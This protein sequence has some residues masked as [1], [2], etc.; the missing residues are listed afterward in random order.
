MS[1][2]I[3]L[4]KQ[5]AYISSYISHKRWIVDESEFLTYGIQTTTAIS[6]SSDIEISNPITAE[7][8][9]KLLYRSLDQLYYRQPNTSEVLDEY[10]YVDLASYTYEKYN[11]TTLESKDVRAL[12]DKAFVIEIPRNI[13]GIAIKPTSF[14]LSTR[15]PFGDYILPDYIDVDY[16]VEGAALP[17]QGNTVDNYMDVDYVEEG[18]VVGSTTTGDL[19]LIDDGNGNL[20]DNDTSTKVGDIIYSHGL[21]IITDET[22]AN[23]FIDQVIVDYRLYFKSTKEILTHNYRC[24]VRETQLNATYNKTA[25]DNT[26]G[27]LNTNVQ[28]SYFEPYVTTVGLYNETHELIAVAKLSKP[29]PKSQFIDTTFVVSLDI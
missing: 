12:G 8:E 4:N 18:Y 20:I 5:D 17:G 7:Q 25:Y 29:H 26:T 19:T 10:G 9:S 6:S 11:T 16:I 3:K 2:F 23:N 13:T 28:N 15:N 27:E 22:I 24:K 1:T 21:V 14:L